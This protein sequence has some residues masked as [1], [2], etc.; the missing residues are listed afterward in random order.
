MA[1]HRFSSLPSQTD[2][3]ADPSSYTMHPDDFVFRTDTTPA[4]VPVSAAQE[5]F[6]QQLPHLPQTGTGSGWPAS[7]ETF[8][9]WFNSL[10]DDGEGAPDDQ[11]PDDQDAAPEPTDPVDPQ[12]EEPEDISEEDAPAPAPEPEEPE[13]TE[14]LP[15]PIP[16]PSMPQDPP[17]LSLAELG[18]KI[19]A[20]RTSV[21]D[22]DIPGEVRV[23]TPPSFGSLTVNPDNSLALVLADPTQTGDL[24]FTVEIEG[25]DG[26][27][28][29]ASHTFS[30]TPSAQE[31]GWG[32]GLNHYMLATD[33]SGNVIV[34]SGDNHRKV[35]VSG[36]GL[37]KADIAAREG[38]NEGAISSWWLEKHPEYGATE[39][40]ALASDVGFGLWNRINPRGSESSNWLLLERGH[41]YEAS[42]LAPR[43]ASGESEL[44]PLHVGAWGEGS[45]P[46][47]TGGTRIFQDN[48]EHIVIQGLDIKSGFLVLGQHSNVIFDDVGFTGGETVISGFGGNLTGI[49][50]RNSRI[51]DVWQDEP[52]HTTSDGKW[53]PHASRE[54]GLYVSGTNGLLLEGNIVDHNG[55]APDFD[56]EGSIEGGHPPSMYSHN[57]YLQWNT[58]DVTMRDSVIMRGASFGVQ[59]RGGGFV[60]DN[61]FLDNNIPLNTL[62]GN[63][64]GRGPVGNYSLLNG[65]IVTS[66]AAR[67]EDVPHIGALDWGIR[68][69]GLLTT[70][71]DNIVAHAND[72]DDASDTVKGGSAL[73][74]GK[75]EDGIFD[76]NTI[77][78]RWGKQSLNAEGLD[79]TQL[80]TT[81][82]QRYTAEL[83][84]M[85]TA[86][87]G[88]LSDYLRSL[89]GNDQ[90][91][92]IQDI[93]SY[94]RA[95]FGIEEN[96]RVDA[97]TLRFVPDARGDG[98]RWDNR[99]NWDTEDLPG[100][101]D[102]DSVDLGG[103]EVNYGG[104]VELE[105]VVF[106]DG[107]K[108]SV[109][110]GKLTINNELSV[111]QG[112]GK[113]HIDRAGQFWTDGYDDTDHLDFNVDGGRF[114]NTGLF[115]GNFD[116]E[117]TS[118][119]TI[120]ATDGAT[121]VLGNGD[122][123]AVTGTEAKVGFDGGDGSARLEIESG[124]ELTFHTAKDGIRG[125]SEFRS[126]AFEDGSQLASAIDI[127]GGT[128]VVDL[129]ALTT[130]D[131]PELAL[132]SADELTGLFDDVELQG[133]GTERDA[134]FYLDYDADEL[135]L[136][137]TSD[138]TGKTDFNIVSEDF[139]VLGLSPAW[140]GT[141]VSPEASLIDL[142]RT[143]LDAVP[144]QLHEAYLD[145]A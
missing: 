2:L 70:L 87:I 60:E 79:P 25:P 103:N 125:I 14:E 116:L 94:F 38:L 142:D 140:E 128:L 76:D 99:L 126:G 71:I 93:L 36:N 66:A 132:L 57:V 8:S 34:E 5:R 54:S 64:G 90:D 102:G 69:E 63:Y 85:K 56:A 32:T 31:G 109:H 52:K 108:L 141:R 68:N 24:S 124:A 106:G 13:E 138:G 65:N 74:H 7:G 114:A 83:L 19:S 17:A 91:A 27:V 123:L 29:T 80:N 37:T 9:D 39:D 43:G 45:A 20:G 21:F 18:T 33:E 16:E 145:V 88:D 101:I 77:I 134:H 107:G 127:D 84:G 137:L 144:L 139:E 23:I 143:V 50:I 4:P 10:A 105:N 15:S 72:P 58:E 51:L 115:D 48:V 135:T 95:G 82:I 61:L 28:Q 42:R 96:S 35:H 12:P 130:A 26:T 3:Q 59:F 44:A 53:S 120:L 117:A 86:T 67:G 92:A 131:T 55:F 30:V 46:V 81:T 110:H 75:G 22:L 113:I 104:M 118:G 11:N 122:R 6:L 121:F 136:L 49:T 73:H 111:G 62:G 98:L 78:W 133:L 112:G 97:A 129:D 119:Q 89:D 47:V 1:D 40:M 100:T 41:E